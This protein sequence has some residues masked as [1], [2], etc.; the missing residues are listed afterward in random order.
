MSG[1]GGEWAQHLAPHYK[2]IITLLRGEG[3]PGP[4]QHRRYSQGCNKP[5]CSFVIFSG[6]S[7]TWQLQQQGKIPRSLLRLWFVRAAETEN[8]VSEAAGTPLPRAD[9]GPIDI[10]VAVIMW[11]NV[12]CNVTCNVMWCEANVSDGNYEHILHSFH[13]EGCPPAAWLRDLTWH[14]T[15]HLLTWPRHLATS[16]RQWWLGTIIS[17]LQDLNFKNARLEQKL[18]SRDMFSCYFLWLQCVELKIWSNCQHQITDTDP[19]TLETEDCWSGVGTN[20]TLY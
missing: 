3:W 14:V 20:I 19:G 12:T 8:L 5:G 13:N 18:P 17:L 11:C 9:R 2:H 4:G 1:A 16:C 15:T 6:P 10:Q 7:Q